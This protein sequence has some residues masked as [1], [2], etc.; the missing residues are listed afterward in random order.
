MHL[1]IKGLK[2]SFIKF[3]KNCIYRFILPSFNHHKQVWQFGKRHLEKTRMNSMTKEIR[4]DLIA[5]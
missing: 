1:Y 2:I 5:V 3:L 4:A